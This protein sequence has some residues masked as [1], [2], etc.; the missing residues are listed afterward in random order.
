MGLEVV[1]DHGQMFTISQGQ[2]VHAGEVVVVNKSDQRYNISDKYRL[3]AVG[4]M[5]GAFLVL[6]VLLA[7]KNGAGSILG[8]AISLAVIVKFLVP[9]ILA[10]HSPLLVSII[11]A[12]VIMTVTIY[13]AHGF[14][15]RTTVAL[16][17]TGICLTLVGVLAVLGV[18][19]LGLTG[20][21]SEEAFSLTFGTETTINFKGMLLGGI[22]IGALG[23]LDDITTGSVAAVFELA[24]ANSKLSFKDLFGRGLVIGREHI[25]SLVNTLVL[26]YAGAALPIF[27]LIVLNPNN[28]PLW[29]ILNSEMLVEEMVRTICGSV[30][31]ILA[32]P[33]TTFL[34][35]WVVVRTGRVN[36]R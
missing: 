34:S 18:E 17:A 27:L 31:L 10:G 21:G 13:L 20:L 19:L 1:V 2:L 26:T 30:G 15:Q 3:D 11:A 25:T 6:V 8:M 22:I 32:V 33:V 9:A 12:G 5:V 16:I 7:G 28:F 23:V 29:T 4:W 35:A 36:S 14:S 24:N